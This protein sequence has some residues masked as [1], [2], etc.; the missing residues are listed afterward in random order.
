MLIALIYGFWEYTVILSFIILYIFLFT[1]NDYIF[2]G[3]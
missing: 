3:Q 1:Y 2:L